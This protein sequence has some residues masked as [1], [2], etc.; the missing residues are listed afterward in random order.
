MTETVTYSCS[1]PAGRV[2][3][4]LGVHHLAALSTGELIDNPRHHRQARRALTKAQQA[5]SRTEK[6]SQR[7][8]KACATLARRHHLLAE[9]RATTVHGIT[10]R[11][12]TGWSEVAI[13][14][15]NVAGMTRSAR[16]TVE[17]PGVNVAAKAGLNRSIL[18]A[19]PDELRR[20]LTYKTQWYGSRLAVCDRWFPSTQACSAC[21]AKAKL[22]L[23]DRVFHC[24]ACGF[25]PINRDHNA[26]RNIAAHA[27]IVAPGTGETENARRADAGPPPRVETTPPSVMKRED[28]PTRVATSAEQ[29]ADHPKP[30][31]QHTL[32][33]VN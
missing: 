27:V 10:K 29:S 8:R 3:V 22:T 4:D 23:A 17:S 31:D 2:G 7:R 20:Q 11:L 24:P 33:L 1:R 5:L 19:A 14:D 28:H 12:A 32:P 9:R 26:A 15:L 21:G 6:G 18:D 30:A 13:E 25:G 16:G